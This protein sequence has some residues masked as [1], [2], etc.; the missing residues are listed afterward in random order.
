MTVDVINTDQ[1]NG[2]SVAGK[3]RFRWGAKPRNEI[4]GFHL[5]VAGQ[6]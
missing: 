3:A 6:Q 4:P 2:F 5:Y 1:M